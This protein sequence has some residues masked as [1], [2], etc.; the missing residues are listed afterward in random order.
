MLPIP[1]PIAFNLF[2]LDIRWYAITMI[3]GI[4]SAFAVAYYRSR[5]FEF[6][7]DSI[8]DFLIIVVPCSVIGARL[9]Y[10]FF[11]WTY[12]SVHTNEIFAIRNGGLAIHGAVLVGLIVAYLFCRYKKYNFF[13]FLDLVAPALAL[14]QCIGRWG[15]YFNME[16]HG[17]ITTVP[18]AIPIYDLAGEIQ[19][20]HPTFLYESIWDLML[21]F[22]IL[23]YEDHREK[24]CGQ[25]ACMY[26]MIY[27]FGR[28]FIEGLRTDSLMFFGLKT[29]QILSIILFVVSFILYFILAKY[30]KP[31]TLLTKEE[32]KE[33]HRIEVEERK[34]KAAAK[35]NRVLKRPDS[36]KNNIDKKK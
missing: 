12:Y 34:L 23:Y 19:Y 33:F 11:R 30:G 26:F 27:S 22:F 13:K 16:A 32:G 18:W 7:E 1:N 20:V 2:G 35:K 25:A 31:F 36:L 17:R 14:G 9:Y 21:F 3:L 24:K 15:N 28:F 4:L 29:A 10:V 6:K 8:L 5:R